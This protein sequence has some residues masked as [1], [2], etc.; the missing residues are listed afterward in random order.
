MG[1]IRVAASLG[2]GL[3]IVGPLAFTIVSEVSSTRLRSKA[4]ALGRNAFQSSGIVFGVAVPY[5]LNPTEGNWKGK[6]GFFFGGTCF[7][8]FLWAY[9]RLPEL[10]DRTYEELDIL[11][12]KRV[13]ARK[14][15]KYE[16]D[17]YHGVD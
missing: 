14:F 13:S 8:S 11:F 1:T 3:R 5:M 17:A 4:L 6:A 15:R 12:E 16:I 10:K 2:V 7:C 9:F